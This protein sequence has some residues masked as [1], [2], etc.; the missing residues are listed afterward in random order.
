MDQPIVSPEWLKENI[1]D[2]NLI[3]LDASQQTNIVGTSEFANLKIPGARSI[4]LKGDFSDKSTD[5][6]NTLPKPKQFEEASRSIG[7]NNTSKIVV[8]DNLGVYTSPRVWWMF[9]AMGHDNIAVL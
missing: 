4:D 7:I 3:V 2:P 5:L 9:K 1:N 8:Y 6:P